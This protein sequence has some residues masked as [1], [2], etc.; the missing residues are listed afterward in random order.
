MKKTLSHLK[1]LCQYLAVVAAVAVMTSTTNAA[2]PKSVGK[3]KIHDNVVGLFEGMESGDLDVRYIPGDATKGKVL[4]K[5]TT[6]SPITIKLPSTFAGVPA[7][8]QFGGGG[9]GGGGQQGGGGQGGGQGGG[10]FGGGGGGQGQ[11]QGGG[12]G[13][14][15]GQQGG[16]GGGGFGGGGG[17]GGFGGGGGGLFNVDSE[18]LR[19]IEVKTVCLEHGKDDPSPKMEYIIVPLE[20]VTKNTQLIELC[21]MVGTG[22][23]PQNAGQ[24]ATW[25]ITD[26]LSWQQLA[27]KD[28]FRSQLTGAYQKFFTTRELQFAVR[29]VNE[30]A[31]RAKQIERAKSLKQDKNSPGAKQNNLPAVSATK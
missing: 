22:E 7:D 24:A 18:K 17:G 3:I 4:I 9:F 28:R 16:G 20:K 5:N 21:R 12:F 15:G 31:S 11:G 8:F 14:G 19:R 2:S 25:H 29:I 23:I 6:K 30:S 10:G 1:S 13:G 26:G 27:H